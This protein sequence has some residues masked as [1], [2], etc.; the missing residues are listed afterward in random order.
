LFSVKTL[1]VE[2][3]RHTVIFCLKIPGVSGTKIFL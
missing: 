1:F 2:R 3:E